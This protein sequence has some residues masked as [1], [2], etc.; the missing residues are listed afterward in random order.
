MALLLRMGMGAQFERVVPDSHLRVLPTR[1]LAVACPCGE[2][3]VLEVAEVVECP[4]LC[5]RWLLRTETSVR[6]A[7]WPRVDDEAEGGG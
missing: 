1:E 2:F 3:V 5:E 7:R 4:G 6:V